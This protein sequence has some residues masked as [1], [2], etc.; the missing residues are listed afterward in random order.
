VGAILLAALA[1]VLA[2]ALT[3]PAESRGPGPILGDAHGNRLIGTAGADVIG[4]L[5]GDDRIVGRRGS[6]M[7]DGGPGLDRIGG[8]PGAD[9]ILGGQGGARLVGGPGRDEF[10][11]VDG[12]PVGGRGRDVIRARDGHPDVINCG[13][14]R[15]IAYVDR[16]EEGVFGC[17]RIV[18]PGTGQKRGARR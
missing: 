17:E 3:A 12:K 5:G 18:Q 11:A 1:A 6:D 4:G 13:H 14:G 9:V 16:V 8:G 15:D 2:V 10:N 7:L